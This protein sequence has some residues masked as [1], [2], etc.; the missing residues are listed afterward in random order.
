MDYKTNKHQPAPQTTGLQ[1]NTWLTIDEQIDALKREYILTDLSPRDVYRFRIT[2]FFRNGELSHSQASTRFRLEST[3]SDIID[4]AATTATTSTASLKLSQIQVQLTQ[5][6]A[7]SVSSLGLKWN[8][9]LLE[10]RHHKD[11]ASLITSKINGFYVYYRKL[12]KQHATHR[13]HNVALYNYTRLSLPL[14]SSP[15]QPLI[16]THL[17]ANLES[18][19]QYEI[20][21]TCYNLNGDLCSFSNTVTGLTLSTDATSSVETLSTKAVSAKGTAIVAAEPEPVLLKSKHSELLFMVLGAALGV[22]SLLLAAFALM[23]VLRHRQHRRLLA[24]LQNTSHK[25]AS[26][27]CPTLIY[28][29]SLRQSSAAGNSHLLHHHHHHLQMPANAAAQQRHYNDSNSTN[30]QSMST[31]TS[32]M[33]T[34]PALHS[35][36]TNSDM[37]QQQQQQSHVL[38]LNGSTVA[39][40]PIPNAPPPSILTTGSGSTLGRSLNIN[41][42]PLNAFLETRFVKYKKYL[43]YL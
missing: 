16:D 4:N 15:A 26:S 34:P 29:D 2:A 8:T 6:W 20:K 21:I 7:V 40:P 19:S 11:S 33:T 39:A 37:Q 41:L 13:Q 30:S 3:W 36:Q 22:L 24:Q 14:S 1:A 5:I 31:T 18:D 38:L 32:S 10:D 42:N 27:S 9:F 23:C 25:L 17:I 43:T 35:A 28:E 12:D